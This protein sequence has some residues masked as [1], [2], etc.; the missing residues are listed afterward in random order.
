MVGFLAAAAA[1]C[2]VT[3]RP[4]SASDTHFGD[5]ELVCKAGEAASSTANAKAASNSSESACR[6]QQ[7]Q[8]VNGGKDIVFLFN[9]VMQKKQPIAIVSTPLNVYL[10]A[11]MDL[12]VDTGPTRKA[13]FE[14]CNVTGCH[15]GFA[16][17]DAL[18]A[19]LRKGQALTV[20]LQDSKT[21]RIPLKVSLKG[22]SAGIEA[23]K[24]ASK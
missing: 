11:G 17:S 2:L 10:P 20:T 23:L 9:I 5:W 19:S 1:F 14:T 6:L 3:M 7:A 13:V 12:K 16:L 22:I 24:M 18:L 21:T 4:V 15:G 8:A